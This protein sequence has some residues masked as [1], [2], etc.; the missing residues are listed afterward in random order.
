M[1]QWTHVG[2]FLIETQVCSLLI[3]TVLWRH[4]RQEGE[5]H[6][7]KNKI[8]LIHLTLARWKSVRI[9]WTLQKSNHSSQSWRVY[10]N[11]GWENDSGFAANTCV[12]TASPWQL[13]GVLTSSP[14]RVTVT[15]FP[16]MS[17]RWTVLLDTSLLALVVRRVTSSTVLHTPIT[18]VEREIEMERFQRLINKGGF[19]SST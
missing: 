14:Q 5:Q 4:Q 13:C 3:G 1:L 12:P 9:S 7:S 11:G 16:D 17:M 6:C 2:S 19:L 18:S 15:S 8:G 10:W